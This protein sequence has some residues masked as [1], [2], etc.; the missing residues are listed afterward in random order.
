M[1][2]LIL[3]ICDVIP[4]GHGPMQVRVR[5]TTKLTDTELTAL[6]TAL[7]AVYG[8]EYVLFRRYSADIEVAPHLWDPREFRRE[9]TETTRPLARLRAVELH[10]TDSAFV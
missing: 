7:E 6:E 10:F 1:D 8:V 9:L 2:R 5:W 3:D 4:S